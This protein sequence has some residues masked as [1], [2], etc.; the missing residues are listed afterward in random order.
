MARLQ[1]QPSTPKK[2]L[3]NVCRICGS[4][5]SKSKRD[6][7]GL[8]HGAAELD[9]LLEDATGVPV[10]E[11]DGLPS[12]ACTAC[13]SKLWKYQRARRELEETRTWLCQAS[14]QTAMACRF[15]R[16]I[17]RSPGSPS[18]QHSKKSD[19]SASPAAPAPVTSMRRR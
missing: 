11:D 9:R 15:K 3:S 14:R 7:V 1:K 2:P 10:R 12:F 19:L 16:R 4:V 8:F 17:V 18:Q 13:R 6:K 5:F